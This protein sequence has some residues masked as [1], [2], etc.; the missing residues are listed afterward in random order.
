MMLDGTIR[1]IKSNE[2]NHMSKLSNIQVHEIM[3]LK[4]SGITQKSL[5]IKYGINISQISRYWNNKTRIQ[6]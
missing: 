4:D 5:A 6:K 1:L 3:K 2:Q